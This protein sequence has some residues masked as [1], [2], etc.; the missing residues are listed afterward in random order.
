MGCMQSFITSLAFVKL[1]EFPTTTHVMSAYPRDYR[2]LR[3]SLLLPPSGHF[4]PKISKIRCIIAR[5][6]LQNH[7]P[8]DFGVHPFFQ[9]IHPL[10]QEM[11]LAHC[12]LVARSFQKDI[13]EKKNRKSGKVDYSSLRSQNSKKIFCCS[14]IYSS[15]P[16]PICLKM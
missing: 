7:D 15:Y 2:W 5:I 10:S 13:F 16:S 9:R 14:K 11:S 3:L 12:E 1:S 6:C 4:R 8:T